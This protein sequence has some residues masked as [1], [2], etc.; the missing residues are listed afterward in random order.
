MNFRS[1]REI[2]LITG[3]QQTHLEDIFSTFREIRGG[4]GKGLPPV[5]FVPKRMQ[6]K[7]VKL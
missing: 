1:I 4:L 2:I 6:I 7:M 5:D 3:Q